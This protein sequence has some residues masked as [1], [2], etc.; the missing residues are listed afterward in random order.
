MEQLTLESISKHIKDKREIR[1]SHNGFTKGKSR[2][3]NM[4]TLYN[5]V[6]SLVLLERAVDVVCFNAGKVFD[7]FFPNILTDKLTGYG[8]GKWAVR[9]I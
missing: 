3:T 4:I 6:T 8:L 7:P 9:W 1:T 2:L 5:E